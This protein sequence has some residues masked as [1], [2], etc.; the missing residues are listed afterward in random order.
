MPSFYTSTDTI[1]ILLYNSELWYHSRTKEKRD[2]LLCLFSKPKVNCDIPELIEQRIFNTA[3]IF[4][5][6][7][8]AIF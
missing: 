8:Q 1:P 3:V 6:K 5:R 2:M 4:Y 7:T